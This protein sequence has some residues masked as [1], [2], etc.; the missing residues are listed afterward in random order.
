LARNLRASGPAWDGERPPG[1]PSK[2]MDAN[3]GHRR[4]PT[5]KQAAARGHEDAADRLYASGDHAL[6]DHERELGRADRENAGIDA[7]RAQLRREREHSRSTE[8]AGELG[9][10]GEV[11]V[12]PDPFDSP[13]AE[14]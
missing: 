12:E 8:R 2:A 13:D 11:G 7:E 9:E 1:V 4:D 3:E 14:R 10:N 6:A 5:A